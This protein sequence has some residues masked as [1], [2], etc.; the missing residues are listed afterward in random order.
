[1]QKGMYGRKDRLIKTK[2]LDAYQRRKKLPDPTRCPSC[3]SVYT[4]GRWSWEKAPE[5]A[6]Q[7]SCPACQVQ[8]ARRGTRGHFR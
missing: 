8:P 5:E 6:Y 7:A 4:K 3:G 1:M 2:R